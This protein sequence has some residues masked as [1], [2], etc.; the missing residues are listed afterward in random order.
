MHFNLTNLSYTLVASL[1][2]GSV[3]FGYL[4]YGKKQEAFVPLIAGIAL[5]AI[6]YLVW[7]A[8]YMSLA[9]IAV[10]AGVFLLRDRF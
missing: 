6:S 5:I 2:W 3:G 4:I 8:L 1:I 7:S 9:S 10:I